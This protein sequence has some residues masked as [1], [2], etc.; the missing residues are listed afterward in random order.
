MAVTKRELVFT[1]VEVLAQA[2]EMLRTLTRRDE[3]CARVHNSFFFFFF[4]LLVLS[5]SVFF[6]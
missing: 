6:F 4:F 1:A 3:T 5:S 2:D